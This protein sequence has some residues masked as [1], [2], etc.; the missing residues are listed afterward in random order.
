MWEKINT[1]YDCN[2][3]KLSS[4]LIGVKDISN[5]TEVLTILLA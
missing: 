4:L 5:K 2:I 1:T 3:V